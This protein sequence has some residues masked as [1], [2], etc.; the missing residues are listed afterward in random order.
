MNG[1]ESRLDPGEFPRIN[2]STIVNIGRIR[3]MHALFHG[4]YQIV[5]KDGVQLTSGRNYCNRL[6]QLSDNRL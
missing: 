1:L 3:E 2:R 5:L 6:Q 4:E